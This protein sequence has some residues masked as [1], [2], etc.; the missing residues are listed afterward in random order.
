MA[1]DIALNSNQSGVLECSLNYTREGYV[2]LVYVFGDNTK[3]ETTLFLDNTSFTDSLVLK[4]AW[5]G[6]ATETQKKED[7]T[8]TDVYSRFSTDPED[9]LYSELDFAGISDGPAPETR[10]VPGPL[11]YRGFSTSTFNYDTANEAISAS[12]MILGATWEFTGSLGLG[13][14]KQDGAVPYLRIQAG[15]REVEVQKK[16]DNKAV[17]C[18]VEGSSHLWAVAFE[19]SGET[20]APGSHW[21]IP[22]S[23][24]SADRFKRYKVSKSYRKNPTGAETTELEERNDL[25]DCGKYAEQLLQSGTIPG[26][27]GSITFSG[28]KQYSIGDIVGQITKGDRA[29][30]V[31]LAI[32]DQYTGYSPPRAAGESG[33]DTVTIELGRK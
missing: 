3:I 30:P 9:D 1:I 29:T 4:A 26:V 16:D 18:I 24:S 32:V 31:N 2:P 14:R 10:G 20:T 12:A 23:V 11:M 28:R 7:P 19:T 15:K 21:F 5:V 13:T 33:Q 8:K 6:E 25:V 17:T 27:S 22:M